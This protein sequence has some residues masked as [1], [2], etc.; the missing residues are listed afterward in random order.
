MM[1]SSGFR[2]NEKIRRSK[3][4]K[5]L[6]P[7]DGMDCL[8]GKTARRNVHVQVL[9]HSNQHPGRIKADLLFHPAPWD[10]PSPFKLVCWSKGSPSRHEPGGSQEPAGLAPWEQEPSAVSV[11]TSHSEHGNSHFRVQLERT[12]TE[13]GLVGEEPGIGSASLRLLLLQAFVRLERSQ[14]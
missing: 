11:Q 5:R 1:G 4:A 10:Q 7:A 3:Q 9:L 13:D 12:L 2:S 14:A 6:E 8:R